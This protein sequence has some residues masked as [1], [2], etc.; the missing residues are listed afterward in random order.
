MPA[1]AP[2]V[3]KDAVAG[4]GATITECEPT[5]EARELAL[6]AV[7]ERTGATFIHPYDDPVIIAGAG[8]TALELLEDQPD[9]D[10][11][12]A[13]VGGGGQLSGIAI[14]GASAGIEVLG[15][16]PEGADDAFRSIRDGTIYP[17]VDPRTICDG[18]LTS[19]SELTFSIIRQHTAGILTVTDDAV[20]E[21]MRLIW[22]RAKLVVEPSGAVTL[23]AVLEHGE[24]LRGRR[25]GLIL[26]GGNVDLDHLPWS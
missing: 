18:L 11:V 12:I 1:P 14:V 10:A 2:Q 20:I 5:L 17:S 16:E 8:T 7:V 26:S 9:L 6:A 3:K 25:L 22:T 13:P 4:Y 21:A 23:A 24:R 19:L 15:S